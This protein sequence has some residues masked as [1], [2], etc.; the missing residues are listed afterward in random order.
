MMTPLAISCCSRSWPSTATTRSSPLRSLLRH[1]AVWWSS[2]CVALDDSVRLQAIFRRTWLHQLPM[3]EE[4]MG[5]QALALLK[6]LE[7]AAQAADDLA[8]ATRVVFQQHPQMAIF[9]SF[10]GLGE[11]PAARLLAEIGDDATRFTDAR[12]L[13]AYAGAAPVTRA[14]GKKLLVL[15][16][17]VKNQRLAAVGYLWTFAALRLSTGARAHYDRRRLA[18]DCTPPHNATCSTAS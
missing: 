8:E 1:R 9:T 12:G 3:V 16:R 11:L 17:K 2:V 5:R 10:P 15:H 7:A 18:G 14:S 4:A 6:Q 13:K